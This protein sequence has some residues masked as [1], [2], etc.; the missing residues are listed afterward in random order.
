MAV[1][2][3]QQLAG[4]LCSKA[5]NR[6]KNGFEDID[7]ITAAREV[8]VDQTFTGTDTIWWDGLSPQNEID[9]Y[10]TDFDDWFIFDRIRNVYPNIKLFDADGSIDWSE[11]V[12]GGTNTCYIKAAMGS[13]AEFP[14]LVRS[15]F[16]NTGF[17]DEGIFN[18]RFYIRGKPWVVTIDD[19]ILFRTE[20]AIDFYTNKGY[21]MRT[22]FV[23]AQPSVDGATVWGAILEKAWAKVK[24]NYLQA[25]AGGL[26]PNG[27][28][29]LTGYPVFEYWTTEFKASDGSLDDAWDL[30]KEGEASDYIMAI[31]TGGE[32]N[33]L[34]SNDC[35]IAESHAYSLIT[36]FEMTDASGTKHKMLLVR[37]PWAS[38]GYNY[39]WGPDDS[40][41]TDALVA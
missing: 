16:V 38:N 22:R 5:V 19:T 23:F 2:S 10:T 35:G 29:A 17:N 25:G 7:S 15:T 30:I 27:L 34:V 40:N 21:D 13:I 41:W 32:G 37:N 11:A 26:T 24:G 39:L 18:V 12:Q 20:T 8:F 3:A 4:E 28:R 33:D 9:N 36:H 31:S 1:S 14:D 6:L